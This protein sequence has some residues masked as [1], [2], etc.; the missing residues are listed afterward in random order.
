MALDAVYSQ[1][2]ERFHLARPVELTCFA[3]C[4]TNAVYLAASFFY[5][6]WLVDPQGQSIPTDFVNVWAGGRHVLDGNPAAAHE[7]AIHKT[8]EV[9]AIGHPF[10]GEYPWIYPPTF[11]FAATLLALL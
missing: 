2:P 7:G 9:A 5:G 4:V 6:S 8:A 1:R 3:L 11:L 10:E